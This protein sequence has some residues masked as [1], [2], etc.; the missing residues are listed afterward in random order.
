M[1]LN[2]RIRDEEV[3]HAIMLNR[4]SNGE[5]KKILKFM[6]EDFFDSF[7]TRL[8]KTIKGLPANF[9]PTAKK[10]LA[11][12][13]RAN[14]KILKAG[15]ER[16]GEEYEK[17][18]L[19]LAAAETRYTMG[20]LTDLGTGYS[21]IGPSPSRVY[22]AAVAKPMQGRFIKD[23]FT[24][25]PRSLVRNIERQIKIGYVNSEPTDRIVRRVAPQLDI[26]QNHVKTLV[27][28]ATTHISAVAREEVAKRNSDVISGI[29]YVAVLDNRTTIICASLDG[30]VYPIDEG[31]RPEQHYNCRSTTSIVVKG[32]EDFPN[33]P[34]G[35]RASMTGAVPEKTT[36]PEWLKD[37]PENIQNEVLGKER[38]KL[39]RSGKFKIS[40][41]IDDSNNVIPVEKLVKPRR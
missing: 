26:A 2:K 27:R 32:F 22:G 33:A 12:M 20:I 23:F 28:T 10:R 24:D 35:M 15:Y 39:F 19:K 36:Y 30:N 5:V 14:V 31:P 1:N 9:T 7:K 41:F 40:Q 38:A 16:L 4:Y 3:R 6:D 25:E 8:D 37:Q 11:Q 17:D 21:F 34:E 18:G 29:Q 13:K